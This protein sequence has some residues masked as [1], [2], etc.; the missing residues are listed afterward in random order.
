MAWLLFVVLTWLHIWANIKALRCLRLTSL[1]EPR[2][3][4]LL[5][6][7]TTKVSALLNKLLYISSMVAVC[8]TAVCSSSSEAAYFSFMQCQPALLS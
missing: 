7:Y 2:L 4:L 5:N 1:N 3:M 6:A 8:P